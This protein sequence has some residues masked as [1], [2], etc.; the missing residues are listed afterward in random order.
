[1]APNVVQM[2]PLHKQAQDNRNGMLATDWDLITSF[3]SRTPIDRRS[4]SN[5]MSGLERSNTVGDFLESGY[6]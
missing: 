2:R 5:T 3:C 1:M 6:N 4:K